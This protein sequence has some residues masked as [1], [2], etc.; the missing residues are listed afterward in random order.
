MRA[1]LDDPMT[2]G[3]AWRVGLLAFAWMLFSLL[4]EE[5]TPRGWIEHL[6]TLAAGLRRNSLDRCVA[7]EGMGKDLRNCASIEEL[8]QSRSCPHC[9]GTGVEPDAQRVA[10]ISHE[11]LRLYRRL[12]LCFAAVM[13]LVVCV[14]SVQLYRRICPDFLSLQRPVHASIVEG[15]S[16]PPLP[17]PQTGAG[18]VI[19]SV[20]TDSGNPSSGRDT[21]E[22]TGDEPQ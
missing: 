9:E 13:I 8:S 12:C 22:A 3:L 16:L 7:C 6:L 1:F 5:R 20:S 18:G 2:A 14:H 17:P 10:Q 11:T 19:T 21:T 15:S 4:R